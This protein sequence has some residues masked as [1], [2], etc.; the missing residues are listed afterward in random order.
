MQSFFL[1]IK[2]RFSFLDEEVLTLVETREQE[3]TLT[4]EQKTAIL[5]I[6][7]RAEGERKAVMEKQEAL[8]AQMGKIVQEEIHTLVREERLGREK[9]ERA[10]EETEVEQLLTHV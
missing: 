3:G 5:A 4:E 7:E 1:L 6:C 8:F 2:E 10:K 9:E